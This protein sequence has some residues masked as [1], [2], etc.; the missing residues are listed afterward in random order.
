VNTTALTQAAPPT[1]R[2]MPWRPLLASAAVTLLVLSLA[3]GSGQS[4]DAFLAIASAALASLVVAAL[5]DPAASLLAAG[6]VSAMQRRLLR[7]VLVTL[8]VLTLWWTLTLISGATS[9]PGP[10]LALAASGVAVTVW[11]PPDRGVLLGAGAPMAWYALDQLV[12]WT[13]VASDVVGWWRTESWS[14]TAV[15]V[16][17]LIVG[18]RR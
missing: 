12:P 8:P 14:V 13:G 11:V 4:V 15:A 1:S 7:L 5:H 9:G 6:P 2:A 18:R 17:V 10:L 16:L 3:R